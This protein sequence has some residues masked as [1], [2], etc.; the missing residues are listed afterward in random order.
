MIKLLKTAYY[1]FVV[2]YAKSSRK[3]TW[4]P[5]VWLFSLLNVYEDG[6][7]CPFEALP[8]GDKFK[9]S[10]HCTHYVG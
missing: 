1:Q 4:S 5:Y 10:T 8:L 3:V 7:F 2:Q 9:Q 6:Q